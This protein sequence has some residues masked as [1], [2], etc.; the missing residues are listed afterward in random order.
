MYSLEKRGT[1]VLFAACRPS[2]LSDKDTD[3]YS[4]EGKDNY[5]TIS[6]PLKSRAP[7]SRVSESKPPSSLRLG[8]EE[9]IEL[10]E[11]C[12]DD[13]EVIDFSQP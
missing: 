10:H 7:S 8:G 13:D 11:D 5:L 9:L 3:P 1:F 2:L 6:R 4:A 12:N